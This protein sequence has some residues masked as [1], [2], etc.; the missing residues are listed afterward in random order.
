MNMR[1][2][3]MTQY[4]HFIVVIKWI[5]CNNFPIHFHLIHVNRCLAHLKFTP[6]SVLEVINKASLMEFEKCWIDYK[7]QMINSQG[8]QITVIVLV[9]KNYVHNCNLSILKFANYLFC[10]S[11]HDCQ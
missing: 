7:F 10:T 2:V 8:R 6:I 3:A 1:I 5:K 4:N 11:V 9:M